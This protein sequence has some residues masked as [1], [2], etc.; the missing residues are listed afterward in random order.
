MSQLQ[1]EL[2]ERKRQYEQRL[3]EQ[4]KHLDEA[5]ISQYVFYGWRFLEE[6]VF[7][8]LDRRNY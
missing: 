1:S 7:N 3:E 8:L 4:I 6:R 2:I 5:F